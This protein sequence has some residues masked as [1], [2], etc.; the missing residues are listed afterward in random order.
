M[1][2]SAPKTNVLVLDNYLM[3]GLGIK[4]VILD[5]DEYNVWLCNYHV[6]LDTLEAIPDIIVLSINR[7]LSGASELLG[8]LFAKFCD[9]KV[10]L[11]I[12]ECEYRDYLNLQL[13][14]INGIILDSLSTQELYS[15]LT[16][17]RHGGEYL[18]NSLSRDEL[19]V[20]KRKNKNHSGVLNSQEINIIEL[21]AEGFT[22][23]SI[24]DQ[25]FLSERTIEWHRRKILKKANVKNTIELVLFSIENGLIE[26]P[27]SSRNRQ[28]NNKMGLLKVV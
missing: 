1:H 4:S 21:I 8:S 11:L 23:K 25:L 26:S 22:N 7:N 6:Q 20:T 19:T 17:I 24:A 2:Y 16:V 5:F 28:L 14:G 3:S 18:S 27:L 13:K 9:L 12:N 10:V 15:C